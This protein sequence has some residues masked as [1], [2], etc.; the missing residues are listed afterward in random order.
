ML[1]GTKDLDL[2][3]QLVVPGYASVV[4]GFNEP[5]LQSQS[6]MDPGYACTLWQQYM[7][8][9]RNE[10]YTL[11]SP[12]TT[13]SPNGINWMKSFLGACGAGS[14]DKMAVHWYGVD[15]QLFIQYLQLWYN[16][17]KKPLWVTE[18]ACQDF[19]G[20]GQSC[21]DVEG[22][23][24]TVRGF[25]DN[26]WWVEQYAPFAVAPSLGNVNAIN[27][28]VDSNLGMTNLAKIYFD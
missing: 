10:G 22:F 12:V 18:F 19:S 17:F 27:T 9:L 4:L 15:P 24:R 21:T 23:A 25:M 28:L 11:A 7:L 5:D 8:P 6:Y 14:V 1:W 20:S 2:W 13:S 3:K 16:T 26:T